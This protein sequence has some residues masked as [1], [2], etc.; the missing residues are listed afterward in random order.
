MSPPTDWR[1]PE[2]RREAFMRQYLLHLEHGTHPG[3]V[4]RV[5]PGLAERYPDDPEWIVWLNGN[6]QNPVMT[7]LLLEKA[8]TRYDWQAA[9]AFWAE[10]KPLLDWDT[11]RRHQ[12]HKFDEATRD[13]VARNEFYG[14]HLGGPWA[15][16]WAYARSLPHMGRLS[17]WSMT[18]YAR[19]LLGPEIPDAP[20]LMLGDKSGSKSHR[21]GLALVAGA[22]A[23]A[24]WWGWDEVSM[25]WTV[26]ELQTLGDSLLQEARERSGYNSDATFLTLESALCTWKSWWKPNRRYPNV[27]TDMHLIRMLKAEK[28]WGPRFP[29]NWAS[30]QGLPVELRRELR[31]ADKLDKLYK[32]DRPTQNQFRDLGTPSI[33]GYYY[34]DMR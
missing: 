29:V 13:W 5:L 17:A 21:N 11:D 10:N 7:E 24:A 26:E 33:L 1:L 27:Y 16:V 15:E 23:D 2:N 22:P 20:D 12:K 4:Y 14:Q 9:V 25:L 18:E 30:R 31:P 8:P 28:T 6:T 3:L 34:E 19:I 32:L